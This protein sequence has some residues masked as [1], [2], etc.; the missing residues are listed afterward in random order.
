MTRISQR[1]YR[2]AHD[3]A[4]A[5]AATT[6]CLHVA[7]RVFAKYFS[8]PW[9]VRLSLSAAAG[10]WFAVAQDRLITRQILLLNTQLLGARTDKDLERFHEVVKTAPLE[11]VLRT[12]KVRYQGSSAFLNAMAERDDTSSVDAW[13]RLLSYHWPEWLGRDNVNHPPDFS[14]LPRKGKLSQAAVAKLLQLNGFSH[15]HQQILLNL[16]AGD[17]EYQKQILAVYPLLDTSIRKVDGSYDF[18]ELHSETLDHLLN[19][20]P[21][22]WDLAFCLRWKGN[23]RQQLADMDSENLFKLARLLINNAGLIRDNNFRYKPLYE[24]FQQLEDETVLEVVKRFEEQ[25]LHSAAL[26]AVVSKPHLFSRLTKKS[27]VARNMSPKTLVAVLKAGGRVHSRTPV[28]T[29]FDAFEFEELEQLYDR[30][31]EGIK[32]VPIRDIGVSLNR[33]VWNDLILKKGK[34]F[35]K[36]CRRQDLLYLL[37][38]LPRRIR[39][40]VQEEAKKRSLPEG[41]LEFSYPFLNWMMECEKDDRRDIIAYALRNNVLPPCSKEVNQNNLSCWMLAKRSKYPYLVEFIVK[42]DPSYYGQALC[43]WDGLLKQ[44]VPRKFLLANGTARQIILSKWKGDDVIQILREK[45]VSSDH[46]HYE[47]KIKWPTENVPQ[48][49]LQGLPK[50]VLHHLCEFLSPYDI[51]ILAGLSKRLF[52]RLTS[53]Q[54]IHVWRKKGLGSVGAVRDMYRLLTELDPDLIRKQHELLS[55]AWPEELLPTLYD[56]GNL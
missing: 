53:D 19:H 37:Q 24:L 38:N 21:S 26:G 3:W 25:S 1:H 15:K 52:I 39:V 8:I 9:P 51:G 42:M 23:A 48:P 17:P 46:G 29:V 7:A 35:F 11:A 32:G 10:T 18:P 56:A 47:T 50:D 28:K 4:V 36:V 6:A 22:Q 43:R 45:L 54:G 31:M 12:K 27:W 16:T 41:K 13:R 44:E 40:A 2:F 20:N 33:K 34:S 14:S 49:T 30:L 55:A 5:T